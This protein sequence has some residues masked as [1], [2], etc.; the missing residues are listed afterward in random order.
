MP[1]VF[2]DSQLVTTALL[3]AA[4]LGAHVFYAGCPQTFNAM[5]AEGALP[6]K[7]FLDR[8]T[9]P[10]TG[11]FKG[12]EAAANCSDNFGLA[13]GDPTACV[14]RWEVRYTQGAAIRANDK[15][16]TRSILLFGHRTHYSIPD[17]KL[18]RRAV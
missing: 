18:T 3:L 15:L 8:Q 9:V 5:C 4:G 16:C 6:A 14:C 11:F 1:A 17:H 12:D 13:A 7:E 2:L 10:F